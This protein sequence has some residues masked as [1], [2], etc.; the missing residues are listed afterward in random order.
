MIFKNRL[1]AAMQLVPYLEKYKNKEG[2]V[3]AVPRGGVPL[4][5]YLAKELEL[6]LDLLMS[7]KLGHPLNPEYA[8][9]A[10]S[11]EDSFIEDEIDV[12]DGYLENEILKIRRQLE[13]RYSKF[14]HGKK[15]ADIKDKIVIIV[16]DG[17]ATGRTIIASIKMLRNNNPKKIVVAV[18]VSPPESAVKLKK[19]VDEFICLHTPHDFYG[20]G[21]FYEDFSEV[22]DDEV[23]QLLDKLN[24]RN[25]LAV[26]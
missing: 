5:F 23:L 3:L 26:K 2:I 10:V 1:D 9:G 11:L 14:M 16:D 22:T 25:R 24:E 18:P 15:H 17:I 21:A 13:E 8:I 20:V 6:P 12:P 4:G 7:K 19:L